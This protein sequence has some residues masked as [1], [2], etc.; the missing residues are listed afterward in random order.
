MCGTCST[1]AALFA[2]STIG[3][4]S[5]R[6]FSTVETASPIRFQIAPP[7]KYHFDIYIGLSPDGKR[8][9]F[10]ATDSQGVA[11]IWVRDLERLD[12]RQLPGTEGAWSPFCSP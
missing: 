5:L 4:A 2:L 11:S 1:I 8:I 3:V 12:A 10:T 6:L 7:P 9:P